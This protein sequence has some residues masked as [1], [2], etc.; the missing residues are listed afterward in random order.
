MST[1]ACHCSI[2]TSQLPGGVTDD[3]TRWRYQVLI[4]LYP[5]GYP[6]N[7]GNHFFGPN[8]IKFEGHCYLFVSKRKTWSEAQNQCRRL[9][10]IYNIRVKGLIDANFNVLQAILASCSIFNF[11]QLETSWMTQWLVWL[12]DKAIQI[13]G[14]HSHLIRNKKKTL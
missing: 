2:A 9:G 8:H 12:S 11:F 13:L 10:V 4:T 6:K 1:R 3:V 14:M 5:A 7:C